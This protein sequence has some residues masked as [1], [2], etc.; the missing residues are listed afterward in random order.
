MGTRLLQPC[1]GKGLLRVQHR[2]PCPERSSLSEPPWGQTVSQGESGGHRVPSALWD[3]R[4][5]RTYPM[6]G[7]HAWVREGSA[8]CVQAVFAAPPARRF[9][10]RCPCRHGYPRASLLVNSPHAAHFHPKT[11]ALL[12]PREMS[13]EQLLCP[14]QRLW[15]SALC[16]PGS[17][18]P[19][20][21]VGSLARSGQRDLGEKTFAWA[22]EA[23]WPQPQANSGG[24]DTGACPP[25]LLSR[26]P[27][28][29]PLGAVGW[30]LR[31]PRR[32]LQRGVA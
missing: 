11:R 3:T 7:P 19:H 23:A 27:D 32:C 21:A 9:P 1:L 20:S 13:Q 30:G 31:R 17:C 22:V 2:E 5:Q 25:R 28:T 10:R 24:G 15:E 18:D 6:A 29:L 4:S 26:G 16:A 8:V 14:G 12:Q